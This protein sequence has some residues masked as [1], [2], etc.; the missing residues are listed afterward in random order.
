MESFGNGIKFH[1][2]NETKGGYNNKRII[3]TTTGTQ[4]LSDTR[5]SQPNVSEGNFY[6]N[7][8]NREFHAVRIKL[9]IMW[10]KITSNKCILSLIN[11]R[12]IRF[13]RTCQ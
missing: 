13:A 4:K 12:N 6:D 10:R 11:R 3:I 2:I 9:C 8:V 5:I 1:H 7:E